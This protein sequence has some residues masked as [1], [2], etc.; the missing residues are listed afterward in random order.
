MRPFPS[1]L[2]L[3]L[4]LVALVAT[5]CVVAAYL[6]T[7]VVD[8]RTERETARI[9][10]TAQSSAGDLAREAA[11]A[12]FHDAASSSAF[13]ECAAA[14]LAED[15]CDVPSTDEVTLARAEEIDMFVACERRVAQ[16]RVER[17]RP[18]SDPD[19]VLA[20]VERGALAPEG[21]CTELLAAELRVGTD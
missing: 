4:L 21:A 14:G 9:L 18:A 15:A 17:M 13:A 20:A 3:P 6:W 5:V 12:T 2:A 1:R 10:I 8:G 19:S 16:A 7:S 11:I